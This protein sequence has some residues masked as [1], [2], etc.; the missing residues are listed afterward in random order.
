[1]AIELTDKI[2][3]KNAA[4]DD[5]V[6][7]KSVGGDGTSSNALPADTVA[8]HAASELVRIDSGDG[9]LEASGSTVASF[10][11]AAQG[12]TADSAVQP[13]G[14]LGTPTSGDLRNCDGQVVEYVG[15]ANGNFNT[16]AYYYPQGSTGSPVASWR[17]WKIAT[18]MTFTAA[19]F[20]ITAAIAAGSTSLTLALYN[21]D[22]AAALFTIELS[23]GGALINTWSGTATASA[24]E[25]LVWRAVGGSGTNTGN[26]GISMA[27][28]G[29][30]T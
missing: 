27:V 17:A 7:A 29:Y 3:P 24:G 1:M 11:T 28:Q 20:E 10:A 25:R 13:G 16:T 18:D 22:T 19:E 4:F 21:L 8:S 15:G 30:R 14:A 23:E 2:A 9:H 5:M 6:D 26:V 12:S